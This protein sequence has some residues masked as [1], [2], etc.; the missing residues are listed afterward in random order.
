MADFGDPPIEPAFKILVDSVEEEADLHPL[1]RLIMRTH[2]LDLLTTRLELVRAWSAGKRALESSVIDQPIFITGMPRSGSTFLHELLAEDPANRAPR[3]WEIMF[4][5]GIDNGS[6]GSV[7]KAEACLWWFRRLAPG[8]DS[9][10]PMRAKTPHEC[11]AI[12]SYTMMSEEFVSTCRVPTYEAFLHS[13]DLT[14]VYDWQKRFLQH[15]QVGCPAMRWVLKSPDH[16]YGLDKLLK[17]FPGAAIIQT[18]RNPVDILNSQI[19]LTQILQ[20]LYAPPLAPN[21]LGLSEA[22]KI[23]QI[24]DYITQFRDAHP[25]SAAK[26]ID[27]SYRDLVSEPIAVVQRI[28]ERLHM[29]LTET[30][31]ERMRALAASRSRYRKSAASPTLAR[32]GLDRATEAKRFRGYCARFGILV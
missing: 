20:R 25:D 3:V 8:A 6:T 4:P 27:V 1:G 11:V 30:A 26:I 16:V 24:S 13:A 19:R 17:I 14:S 21:E 29:P 22:R 2:L 23:K 28:Y 5:L 32:F 18:H 15:L 9:V 12:H 10:Y 31:S 7:Q